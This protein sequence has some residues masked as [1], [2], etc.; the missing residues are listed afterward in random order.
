MTII[1]ALR[2]NGETW[3]GS[4]TQATECGQ[5]SVANVEK[6]IVQDGFALGV[7][8]ALAFL[9]VLQE[10]AHEIEPSWTGARLWRWAVGHLTTFG[11]EPK[12]EPGV[13]PWVDCSLIFATTERVLQIC[14]F[15][16]VVDFSAGEFC[17]R[18]SGDEYALGAAYAMQGQKCEDVMK[19]AI[20][21]AVFNDT[22]CGGEVWVRRL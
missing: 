18:G 13:A 5:R 17:A 9:N 2:A 6:W 1:C 22:G 14:A 10:H 4:D 21:A 11:V 8:G 15:G 3:I 20:K 12:K 16:G 7:C 19:T